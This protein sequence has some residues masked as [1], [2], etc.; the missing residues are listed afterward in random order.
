[1]DSP[2]KIPG[3]RSPPTSDPRWLRL[4]GEHELHALIARAP[5]VLPR[6]EREFRHAEERFTKAFHASPDAIGIGHVSTGQVIDVNESWLWMTGYNRDEV[7][8]PGSVGLNIWTDAEDH[9]TML[10][11]LQEAGAVRDWE[12]RFRKK[13]GEIRRG[14]LSAET[15]E[16]DGQPCLL[17]ICRDVT[18]QEILAAAREREHQLYLASVRSLAATVDAR[19]AYTHSHSQ[20]VAFYCRLI[21][22]ELQLRP[23]DAETI[24]LAGLLHDIG[25]IAIPDGVLQKPSRLTREEWEIMRTHAARGAD[26][27]T[28]GNNTVLAPIVPMVRHHHERWSGNGY[29]AGLTGE[30]I[31]LGAL[32]IAVAD[33]F[34]TITTA[35]PY[36]PASTLREAVAELQRAAGSQ[37][38][39]QIVEAFVRV[40]D[41]DTEAGA[42]YL[43]AIALGA[44]PDASALPRVTATPRTRD[45]VHT[46]SLTY[47]EQQRLAAHMQSLYQIGRGFDQVLNEAGVGQAAADLAR[48]YLGA[49]SVYLL[50]FRDSRERPGP[51]GGPGKRPGPDSTAFWSRAAREGFTPVAVAVTDLAE[52]WR[53]LG[54][55]TQA[56]AFADVQVVAR[57]D[58]RP[59]L[60]AHDWYSAIFIPLRAGGETLA[61]LALGYH[62]KYQTFSSDDLELA[63]ALGAEAAR[64]L[65]G[66]QLR[67]AERRLRRQLAA[68]AVPAPRRGRKPHPARYSPL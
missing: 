18:D 45:T 43:Q 37:F 63:D 12:F 4:F 8:G 32:V 39:P 48:D 52:E 19:D 14:L 57:P 51:P 2:A 22:E 28:A 20:Q 11:L 56:T 42:T 41:R 36:K 67:R 66:L 6:I 65:A 1:M 60:Q 54:Q 7:I 13:S 27:L 40:L 46:R 49:E 31:P 58:L 47:Q 55:A 34:D 50:E 9:Q 26:I 35:R 25:K 16:I 24:E 17:A 61:H 21:T 3:T 10:A 68:R 59:L 15:I 62:S 5:E 38:Q 44:E 29:P 64:A 53:D 23:E 33:A 30:A